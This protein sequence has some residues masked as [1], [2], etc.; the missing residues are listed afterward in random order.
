MSAAAPALAAPAK[1]GNGAMGFLRTAFP[2]INAALAAGGPVGA[3]AGS[4]FGKAIGADKPPATVQDAET[5]YATALANHNAPAEL[6][7]AAQQAELTFKDHAAQMGY[8]SLEKLTALAVE[9]RK[10]ARARQIAVRDSTPQVG[11]YILLLLF[12]AALIVLAVH[13]VPDSN[14]AL[15]F[16]MIGTLGT[17][18][19]MAATFFYG[20]TNSSARKTEL[21]AQAQ[22]IVDTIAT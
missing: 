21:L 1:K 3:L 20:T 4:L 13:P 2:F 5:S 22:P 7:A 6:I 16:G 15:V 17:L 11:F 14:K 9:D 18:V 12:I 8:D 19:V 10:D